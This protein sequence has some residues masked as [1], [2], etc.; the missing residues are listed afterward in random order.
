MEE[1]SKF[2]TKV[3]AAFGAAVLVVAVLAATTWKISRD[4][5]AAALWMSHTHEVLNS[6]AHARGDTLQI[7]LSTQSYR[8]SGDA[9]R[10]AERDAAISARETSLRRLKELTADNARQQE[11]W[12]RL[13]EV[14]DERLAISR[15]A[16]LLRETEGLE[17]AS[18]YVAGAPL[19]E[20]QERLFRLLREMEQ[21]ERRLL[22]ERSAEQLRARQ[23]TVAA[24][25]LVAV[26]LIALLTA[27]YV[28]IRRQMR[29]TEANRAALRE[30]EENLSTTLHSIGDAVL[31]TDTDGRITRMNPVAERLTGWPFAEARG[32]PVDEVFRIVNEETH[33]P[34]IVPVAK[35]LATGEIQGLANHT[36]LIARDDTERPVAD[37]AAPIR[38]AG[39]GVNGV[40][41][42]FR[43]VTAERQAERTIREQNE[44]LEQ[45]VLE[46]TA[47]LRESEARS[48]TIVENLGEGVVV[49][50]LDGQVLHFNRSAIEMHGFASRDEYLRRLPEFADTF[51]LSSADGAPMPVDRWPLAR[52]LRGET[53]RDLEV[54][55]RRIRGEWQ[56]IFNY[57]GTLVRDADGQPLLAVVTFRDITER[58]RAEE[59]IRAL[60]AD[61]ERRVAERTEQL[62]Y[63]NRAK[64]SFLAAMSH[65]VRTPLGGLLG[66]LELLALSPLDGEQRETLQAARASGRS[67]ARIVD[68]ILDWSK[69]E[70]GKLELAPTAALIAEIVTGAANTYARIGSAKGLLLQQHVDP[71]L[72]PAL[73]VDPLRLSQ[74]LN[75]FVSNAIKFTREGEIEIR[76][77]LLG[78]DEGVERVRFSVRDTG[79]GIDKDAQG[80]LFQTYVQGG[81]ETARM[82]GGTGLGLAICRR[83]ADMMNGQIDVESTPGWGSIFSLTLSLPIAAQAP[84]PGE[85]PTAAVD[86][87][88]V[89]P[90]FP[91]RA[92]AEA[93]VVL[94]V[95]DHPINRE[96]LARQIK[97]LGLR[98]ETAVSGANALRMWRE[99]RFDMVITDCHMPELDGYALTRAIREIEATEARSR[100]PI[101]AWTANVLSEEVER[102]RA[103]GMDA[104]LTKPTG[105]ARLRM[106]LEKWLPG[107]EKSAAQPADPTKGE[108]SR[109]ADAPID[110]AQ[111]AEVVTES[112]EQ[113]EILRS[114][115]SHS[116]SQLAELKD[117]LAVRDLPAA[118][119]AAHRMKGA[120][121]MVGAGQIAEICAVIE[122]A[123]R[124]G[125]IAA[126]LSAGT[127]LD[128]AVERFDRELARQTG[129]SWSS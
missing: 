51:E 89:R 68:D 92:A 42:V 70:A 81:A 39:G 54:R 11:R 107:A 61:L 53:L 41:L 73:I 30:S 120:S 74:V 110:F 10:L 20:T 88:V 94:V 31:A 112:A 27:T 69:I 23:I 16:V 102:C 72:S 34:A 29:A 13:R 25:A 6:L 113:L 36:V 79:V 85:G 62:V 26:M 115:Q 44:L 3:L 58:K 122:E 8:I 55:I 121:R 126:T 7:E 52:I 37:S 111:L 60:N 124:R 46:R 24:G 1:R 96:L 22:E 40:V 59:E 57:G 87:T 82:Y 117:A 83:L 38:D 103:A 49:A 12:T 86:T 33:A 28:L 95:D 45:R 93:P 116:S 19:R 18:A 78:R 21:E 17:A 125:D 43:D 63:A 108:A 98:A 71:R 32:R 35:V 2:E 47:Q 15:R 65:E 50:N 119:R 128:G 9:A 109:G 99:G 5:V 114:F 90:L 123:A 66:M 127:L 97:L 129:S 14:V 67:L 105:L 91:R 76:A 77:E 106:T 56:R 64:D 118:V 4:A 48:Q 100:S 101:I 84:E 80:R 104:L 75:N